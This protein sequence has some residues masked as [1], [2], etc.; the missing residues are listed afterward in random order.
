MRSTERGL[1]SSNGAPR[2]NQERILGNTRL[3]TPAVSGKR[4]LVTVVGVPDLPRAH[5][6][7]GAPR[8]VDGL[9]KMPIGIPRAALEQGGP[10]APDLARRRRGGP[11]LG[12]L[13]SLLGRGRVDRRRRRRLW[14]LGSRPRRQ[15]AAFRPARAR[16]V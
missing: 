10:G 9:I 4:A 2:A 12:A 6:R 16:R 5:R 8:S 15:E 11:G 1:S 7:R 14:F 3:R 13:F